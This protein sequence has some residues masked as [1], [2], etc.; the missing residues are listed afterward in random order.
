MEETPETMDP[1]LTR[2]SE[3]SGP[4]SPLSTLPPPLRKLTSYR[5]L[6]PLG[7]GGMGV[8]Y[9]ALDVEREQFVALKTLRRMSPASFTR[10]KAEFRAVAD[11]VHENLVTLHELRIEDGVPYFTM[12]LVEGVDFLTHVRRG[13]R[14]EALD[15]AGVARLRDALGQL[16][17]GVAAL[18]RAGKVHR[19]LKRS[20]VIVTREGR[21]VLL[22]FGLAVDTA[23]RADTEP[24][25]GT[26]AY[27]SPEQV[28]GE[29]VTRAADWFGVGVMLYRALTGTLPVGST[30]RERLD[31]INAMPPAPSVLVG[32][33]P[34]DLEELCLALLSPDPRDRPFDDE[35]LR[36]LNVHLDHA[37][38]PRRHTSLV[39]RAT[40]LAAL[41]A[42][43]ALTA[44][45]HC[46]VVEV[47]G[48]SG[49]GKSELVRRWLETITENGRGR[50]LHSRCRERESFAYKVFDGWVEG[51]AR[52]LREHAVGDLFELLPPGMDALSRLFPALDHWRS[53][54][55]DPPVVDRQKHRRDAVRCLKLLLTRLA[56]RE[57]LVLWVD[58]LQ[59]IDADSVDMLDAVFAAPAPPLMLV[60]TSR[61]PR[62]IRWPRDVM[63]T[64]LDVE[65]LSV[66]ESTRLAESLGGTTLTPERLTEIAQESHGLPFLIEQMVLHA[67]ERGAGSISFDAVLNARRKQLPEDARRILDVVAVAGHPIPQT[68]AI[69]V[70]APEGDAWAA[71]ARLRSGNLI[72]T[73][74]A[75]GYDA[76]E[77]WHDRIREAIVAGLTES[78]HAR[79]HAAIGLALERSGEVDPALLAAHFHAAWQPDKAGAYAMLAAEHA[80]RTLAFDR[81]AELYGLALECEAGDPAVLLR[82]RADALVD[83]GRCAEAAPLYQRAARAARG[84]EALELKRLAA[85]QLMV[86]GRLDEGVAELRPVLRAAG[87]AFPSSTSSALLSMLWRFGRAKLRGFDVATRDEASVPPHLLRQIDLC[88][89]AVKGLL[90]FDSITAAHFLFAM[91]ERAL[92]AGEPHRASRALMLV[93]MVLVF[94]GDPLAH[95]EGSRIIARGRRIAPHGD[96]YLE[97]LH[98]TTRGT[99][100][101]SIGAFREGLEELE[102]GIAILEAHCPSV[103]WECSAARSSTFT[104]LIW[105]GD[106]A[107]IA[108]R[109]PAWEHDATR[110]GDLF[111]IVTAKLYGAYA[112]LAAGTV[113]EARSTTDA[114]MEL[115]TDRGFHYQHW[116][117]EKIRIWCDLYQ[118]RPD[119]ARERL[120]RCKEP[121]SRSG[122][123]RVQLMELDAYLL[124]GIV[125]LVEGPGRLKEVNRLARRLSR[126]GR[127]TAKAGAALL[128]AQVAR[129]RGK[130]KAHK[131]MRSAAEAFA[132]CDL[133]MLALATQRRA[134]MMERATAD[135]DRIDAEL[136]AMGVAEP[137][138]WTALFA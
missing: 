50:T 96:R 12:E 29:N 40:E 89:T 135:L 28:R 55:A 78:E 47:T 86:T 138:R 6:E 116:L 63:L 8:V 11:V 70:A 58:D 129:H 112:Q 24:L 67:E 38:A 100:V 20:N 41:D 130:R 15:E 49:V 13:N 99:A 36:W 121:L 76:L 25:V 1:E 87:L 46:V 37:P 102:R 107:E 77:A 94:Q 56:R 23:R 120:E 119:R 75:R 69:E 21:V 59:W 79:C 123:L 5:V 22:D 9:R 71:I 114:A 61:E 82:S 134:A 124:E 126:M 84:D 83:G 31:A 132:A 131:L 4:D 104:S 57:P 34:E 3:E 65:P 54:A 133:N 48:T 97:G 10:L 7:D 19:D 81:A 122:L 88:W 90:S 74:G 35:V 14:K 111:A 66:A 33:V 26:P 27:M 127:P 18:H 17:L 106:V 95:R 51:I 73:H 118:G 125:C 93:G 44:Q 101:M 68:V 108:R 91:L 105:L 92:E 53:S 60:A 52:H 39:G 85:E 32:P 2:T 115:W 117:A 110:V 72:K 45:G 43:L 16:A 80:T 64:E 42:A 137:P 98:A 30:T 109:A 103:G 113:D 62:V 128:R 136:S